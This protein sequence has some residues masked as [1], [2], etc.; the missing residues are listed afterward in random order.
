MLDIAVPHHEQSLSERSD[1]LPSPYRTGDAFMRSQAFELPEEEDLADEGSAGVTLG[2]RAASFRRADSSK[3]AMSSAAAAFSSSIKARFKSER[4]AS[5]PAGLVAPAPLPPPDAEP[6]TSLGA[7]RLSREVPSS[8]K[9][10]SHLRKGSGANT[11]PSFARKGPHVLGRRETSFAA[12]QAWAEKP[13]APKHGDL[14]RAMAASL[15]RA[16]VKKK[17][18][19]RKGRYIDPTGV[20]VDLERFQWCGTPY[21]RLHEFGCP[22]AVTLYLEFLSEGGYLFLLMALIALPSAID[23]VIRNVR[24]RQCRSFAQTAA[25]AA[26]LSSFWSAPSVF[27][28]LPSGCGYDGVAL[29][30]SLP[31]SF[32][33][34]GWHL[35][36]AFGTCMEY[37]AM[38]D[39]CNPQLEAIYQQRLI[40]GELRVTYCNITSAQVIR[41]V[42]FDV[43]VPLNH[44]ADYCADGSAG[45][46][47]DAR[48]SGVLLFW[49]VA[50]N[51]LIFVIF[52][53]RVRRMQVRQEAVLSAD[54]VSGHVYT[55]ADFAAM[56]TGLD[57]VPYNDASG[58]PDLE[59]RLR[60]DLQR[61]GFSAQVIDHIEIARNCGKEMAILARLAT[62]KAQ[63]QELLFRLALQHERNE[64]APAR[65]APQSNKQM[66]KISAIRSRLA[67]NE[68]ATRGARRELDQLVSQEHYTTGH[69]FIV[70]QTIAERDRFISIFTKAPHAIGEGGLAELVPDCIRSAGARSHAAMAHC[71]PGTMRVL[72]R[73]A[74]SALR[75][76]GSG[77]SGATAGAT[78]VG[79]GGNLCAREGSRRF[80]GDFREISGDFREGSRRGSDAEGG[81][82]A[83][84]QALASA[85]W[86]TSGVEVMRAPE[87]NDVYWENLELS[88]RTRAIRQVG[89]NLAI[90]ILIIAGTALLYFVRTVQIAANQNFSTVQNDTERVLSYLSVSGLAAVVT[91]LWNLVLRAT[92]EFLTELECH[93]TRS[94]VELAVFTKLIC[95]YS[96]NTVAVPIFV[97]VLPPTFDRA[98]H[99]FVGAELS[100]ITQAWYESGGV[101]AQAA[102]LM[103]TS[104]LVTDLLRY[105]H[106]PALF[107]RFVLGRFAA[108]QIRLNQLWAPPRMP[109]GGV[110]AETFRSI[111]V[112]MV[113]APIYPPAFLIT[114]FALFSNL[115]STRFAIATWYMRPPL[116]D[117]QL[118]KR[119]RNFCV[120]LLLPSCLAV[121]MVTGAQSWQGREA[122]GMIS[123]AVPALLVGFLLWLCLLMLGPLLSRSRVYSTKFIHEVH[124]EPQHDGDSLP[125]PLASRSSTS[126]SIKH[127]R[128]RYCDVLKTF[129]YIIERYECP[130]ASRA[131]TARHLED[132]AFRQGFTGGYVDA[133]NATV[134]ETASQGSEGSR[135]NSESGAEAGGGQGGGTGD[136]ESAEGAAGGTTDA[137][138][139]AS[140]GIGDASSDNG[141]DPFFPSVALPAV[142]EPWTVA[143][144][145]SV[146]S[147]ALWASARQ[148]MLRG[149]FASSSSSSSG[150]SSLASSSSSAIGRG[151]CGFGSV[152]SR[153]PVILHLNSALTELSRVLVELGGEPIPI[154]DDQQRMQRAERRVQR[155]L[156][157]GSSAGGTRGGSRSGGVSS[158]GGA[159][160]GAAAPGQGEGSDLEETSFLAETG[161][162]APVQASLGYSAWHGDAGAPL[163]AEDAA[164]SAV[165]AASPSAGVSQT[166]C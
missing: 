23:A 5:E 58:L 163:G 92:I 27:D 22:I 104:S 156:K 82:T 127:S 10:L 159:N 55:A 13:D 73:A 35:L 109:L 8:V 69:A 143:N 164:K 153:D 38:P 87:P 114:S 117:G 17:I 101:V 97:S 41:A 112:G 24:R 19:R 62:L 11:L 149:D 39:A 93:V 2:S 15:M 70:F 166:Q 61:L 83:A 44:S 75:R 18:A 34:W 110:Y 3:S 122:L 103:L 4:S 52:L 121:A 37:A 7:R 131:K 28:G 72:G 129:G 90:G 119:M 105:I 76:G 135:L 46:T 138:G 80:P 57:Q 74:K 84:K 120:W 65:G 47:G 145:P 128:I 144:G 6:A 29:R 146:D 45:L 116:V 162:F 78:A 139:D 165:P 91:I 102:I 31:M 118:M 113:Y 152:V 111:C 94:K 79:E 50:L 85:S 20:R 130:A 36:P 147:G 115:Y 132:T 137:E 77:S 1:D 43:F 148:G 88:E 126:S 125:P 95:A 107:K 56:V 142:P 133:G 154:G 21:G 140:S 155:R 71:C 89:T 99:A 106:F 100:G 14:K 124:G 150:G 141:E 48:L 134:L 160:G 161:Y 30:D 136:V 42:G 51:A 59:R 67:V 53:L 16:C 40:E 12:A 151:A 108:S 86:R 25:D 96:L 158:A 66:A 33:V 63:R 26:S 64:R 157:H 68:V 54:R 32:D 9:R 49:G 123:Q 98:S 81:A 60:A